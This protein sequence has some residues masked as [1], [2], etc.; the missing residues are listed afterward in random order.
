[1]CSLSYY[2]MARFLNPALKPTE[3]FGNV[4]YCHV[5]TP[6][7]VT[8]QTSESYVTNY[9]Y[10]RLF[11]KK[12]FVVAL[13]HKELAFVWPGWPALYKYPLS[14]PSKALNWSLR[15]LW[16]ILGPATVSTFYHHVR[17]TINSEQRCYLALFPSSLI[18]SGKKGNTRHALTRRALKFQFGHCYLSPL[19]SCFCPM[20]KVPAKALAEAK[21]TD[22]PQEHNSVRRLRSCR[23]QSTGLDTRR[24]WS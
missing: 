21:N 2:F 7:G 5:Q 20:R 3:L 18:E 22:K 11:V 13:L 4:Q 24:H 1:M 14:V 15:L 10:S 12:F 16:F 23:V 9:N 19:C 8:F 6:H 17:G